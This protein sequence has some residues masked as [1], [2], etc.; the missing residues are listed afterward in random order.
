MKAQYDEYS[1]I[2]RKE[3]Y[4]EVEEKV[5]EPKS[6]VEVIQPEMEM[7]CMMVPKVKEVTKEKV[8]DKVKVEI[9]KEEVKM[10][11]KKIEKDVKVTEEVK[12]E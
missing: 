9:A 12:S 11:E 6:T 7:K 2:L 1:D 8:E 3:L 5:E 4:P 10:E